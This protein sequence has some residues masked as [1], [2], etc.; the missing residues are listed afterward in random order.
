MG[1]TVQRLMLKGLGIV[2]GLPG[3]VASRRVAE[4]FEVQDS[5]IAVSSFTFFIF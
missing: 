1:L 2:L 5:F 3:S 4:R